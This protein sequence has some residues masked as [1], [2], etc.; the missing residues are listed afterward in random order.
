MRTQ[1]TGTVKY[2]EPS[3][4]FFFIRQ[5]KPSD[6]GDLFG[7]MHAIIH[8]DDFDWDDVSVGTRLQ[9]DIVESA[10]KPGKL[11][12]VNIRRLH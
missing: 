9:Y 12:A 11:E 1:G 4:G 2:V 8:S 10:R 3:R 5:D 7:H 6:G